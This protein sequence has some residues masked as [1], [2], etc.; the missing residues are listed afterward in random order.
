MFNVCNKVVLPVCSEVLNHGLSPL[1]K[2]RWS[3]CE[4]SNT[5]TAIS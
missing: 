3:V 2:G 1:D 5:L 4:P